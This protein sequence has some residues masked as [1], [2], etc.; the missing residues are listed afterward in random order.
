[1]VYALLVHTAGSQGPKKQHP[2]ARARARRAQ[3]SMITDSQ[4]TGGERAQAKER[5]FR[6][7]A[8]WA[9]PPQQR[10]AANLAD[11]QYRAW[12]GGI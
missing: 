11:L 12:L 4:L 3:G 2:T 9:G 6:K 5:G 10:A 7:A 1:M 8:W